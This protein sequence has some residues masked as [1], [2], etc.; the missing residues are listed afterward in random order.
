MKK[1]FGGRTSDY[2]A[3]SVTVD[4]AKFNREQL[5]I[6]GKSFPFAMTLAT[7]RLAKGLKGYAQGEIAS[8]YDRPTKWTKNSL[9][10]D[11]ARKSDFPHLRAAVYFKDQLAKGNA[12]GKYLHPTIIGSARKHKGFESALIHFGIM[13]GNEYAVP[14]RGLKLDQFGNVNK[15]AI[16]QM[17]SQLQAA[18]RYAGY[19]ANETAASREKKY[20]KNGRIGRARYFV[21]QDGSRLPRGVYSRTG[22]KAPKLFFLFVTDTPD[23]SAIMPFKEMQHREAGR[24]SG[25]IWRRTFYEVVAKDRKRR[26]GR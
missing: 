2:L 17:L 20:G 3:M 10:V 21:P 16:K 6:L 7:T 14:A 22:R 23:Y 24:I 25:K 8:R 15:G 13:R 9:F 26:G 5:H 4:D 19:A 18:E 12:A 1:F 11:P